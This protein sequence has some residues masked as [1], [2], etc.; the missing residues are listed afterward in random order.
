MTQSSQNTHDRGV[1]YIFQ[2]VR[3]EEKV[4]RAPKA[5]TAKVIIFHDL[6][7]PTIKFHEFQGLE[8]EILEVHDFPGFQWPI[9]ALAIPG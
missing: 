4:N 1:A 8:N 6:P 2:G 5:R 9:R 3:T 7:S